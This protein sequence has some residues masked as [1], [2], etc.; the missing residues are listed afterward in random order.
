MPKKF[1]VGGGW[2]GGK[3]RSHNS[4]IWI[5]KGQIY[6]QYKKAW[7]KRCLL[8]KTPEDIQ[9]STRKLNNLSSYSKKQV[10]LSLQR[11][12]MCHHLPEGPLSLNLNCR[13]AAIA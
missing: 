7:T 12:L 5:K 1:I 3:E 4:R 11:K 6:C 13:H 8:S 10:K 9:T 2:R